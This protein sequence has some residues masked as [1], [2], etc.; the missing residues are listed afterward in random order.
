MGVSIAAQAD[1][2]HLEERA[3]RALWHWLRGADFNDGETKRKSLGKQHVDAAPT[4]IPF[5]SV[6]ELG[7]F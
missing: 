5:A 6:P 2:G 4:R 7:E 1:A 3:G